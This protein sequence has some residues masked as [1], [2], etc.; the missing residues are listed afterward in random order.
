MVIYEGDQIASDFSP[1]QRALTLR[2]QAIKQALW[3]CQTFEYISQWSVVRI[4]VSTFRERKV[5]DRIKPKE[6]CIISILAG[7]ILANIPIDDVIVR[8]G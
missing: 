4:A 5:Q 6:H 8:S 7:G 2:F 3:P 1:V